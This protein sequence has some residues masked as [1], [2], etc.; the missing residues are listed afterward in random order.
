MKLKGPTKLK[1][2]FPAGIF[3]KKPTKEFYV[4]TMKPKVDLFLFV[5]L[6]EIEDT[7]QIFRN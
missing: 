2:F 6:E 4:N 5:F 7:K 3:S 1:W